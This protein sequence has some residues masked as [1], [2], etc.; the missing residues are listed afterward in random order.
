[1]QKTNI[2]RVTKYNIRKKLGKMLMRKFSRKYFYPLSRMG[3]WSCKNLLQ[4]FMHNHLREVT[5]QEQ[6]L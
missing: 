6:V 3:S 5:W 2:L 4:D 1:M